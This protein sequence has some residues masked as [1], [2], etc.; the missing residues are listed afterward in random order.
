MSVSPLSLSRSLFHSVSPRRF[1]FI[2][3]TFRIS[4][5]HRAGRGARKMS[6]E[7]S[8]SSLAPHLCVVLPPVPL[9]LRFD[10]LSSGRPSA[11]TDG[12]P[13]LRN[14]CL[15]PLQTV[16]RQNISVETFLYRVRTLQKCPSVKIDTQRTAER[17]GSVC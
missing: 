7:S 12:A 9:R 11:A 6:S 8:E 5:S 4:K 13:I 10:A 17:G 15:P 3:R 2:Q 1:I 16:H 14:Q